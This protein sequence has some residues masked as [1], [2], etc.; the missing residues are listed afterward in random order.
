MKGLLKKISIL[1]L[2]FALFM[3]IFVNASE[4]SG[5]TAMSLED[6]LKEEEIEYNFT[7]TDNANQVVIYLFRGKG[8]GYCH[9]FLE[10]AANTLMKDYGDKIRFVTYEVWYNENNGLLY[11]GIAEMLGASAD[12]VPFIVIGDQYF[13]GYSESMNSQI[14]AK[15]ES[16]YNSSTRYDAL[17]AYSEYVS[18]KESSAKNANKVDLSDAIIWNFLFT[19]ASTIIILV[20]VNNKFNKLTGVKKDEDDEDEY[21]EPELEEKPKTKAKAK[22][23]SKK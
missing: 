6:A 23:K 3:P 9:K 18:K 20:F 11:Q 5:F 16:E 7:H 19:T 4:T 8:C 1:T 14:T 21:D 2:V 22:A 13:T 10:Y 12:G 17:E 15:I